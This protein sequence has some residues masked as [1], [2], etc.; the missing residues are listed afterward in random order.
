MSAPIPTGHTSVMAA[1]APTAPDDLD[2]FPTPPWAG[3]AGAELITALDPAAISCWEPACGEGHLAHGLAD[4]FGRP[5]GCSDIHAYGRGSVFD[6]LTP[7]DPDA[8][9]R[10]DWI[11]TNPPFIH[12]E[13]FARLALQRARRGVAL[14]LR[15]VFLEGGKRSR[16]FAEHPPAVVAPFCERVPMI[17]GR[18]DPEASSA[19]AYAWFIWLKDAVPR[20]LDLGPGTQLRWIMPGCKARLSRSSDRAKFAP[21]DGPNLF[22]DE[23]QTP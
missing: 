7:P 18:W 20:P 13:A 10:W 12:G 2:Y 4:Y 8:E 22:A 14:L 15:L 9:E 5:I 3:R 11:V 17:K 1:R 16:L 6:F 23:G 19:T 21:D